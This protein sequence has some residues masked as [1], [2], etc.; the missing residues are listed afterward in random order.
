MNVY[1]LL[2]HRKIND[3]KKINRSTEKIQN[4]FL[5]YSIG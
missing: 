3:K 4:S 5:N 2:K 1:Y